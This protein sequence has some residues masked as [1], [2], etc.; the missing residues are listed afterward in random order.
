MDVVGHGTNTNTKRKDQAII[1]TYEQTP[2]RNEK[3]QQIHI[4]NI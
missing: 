4:Y 2:I 3:Y 1:H